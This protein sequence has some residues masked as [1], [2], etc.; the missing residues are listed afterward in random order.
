MSCELFA[1]ATSH[2]IDIYNFPVY[3]KHF[4]F[5]TIINDEIQFNK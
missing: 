2:D 5:L 3:I 1:N 4:F